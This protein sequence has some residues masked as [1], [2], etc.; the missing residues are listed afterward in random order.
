MSAFRKFDQNGDG[1]IDWDEFQQVEMREMR[2]KL[3]NVELHSVMCS[4][5]TFQYSIKN[6]KPVSKILKSK[7]FSGI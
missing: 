3:F 1:V 5:I 2:E 7:I 6:Q 4:S